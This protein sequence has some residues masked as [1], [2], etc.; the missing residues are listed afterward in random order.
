ML[1]C[2]YYIKRK[3]WWVRLWHRLTLRRRLRGVIAEDRQ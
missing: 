3:P 2:G 1:I